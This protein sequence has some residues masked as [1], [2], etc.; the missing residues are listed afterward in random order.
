V[1]DVGCGAGWASIALARAY[2][3]ARIDGFDADAASVELAQR[4]AAREGVA[5]RVTFRVHDASD[6][7]GPAADAAGYDYDLVLAFETVHDLAR[8]V[9]AL[10]TMSRLARP[11]GTVLVAEHRVG[12]AFAAPGD[13]V[14]RL[15]Y[16][17]S[18]L[19]CLPTGMA[20]GTPERPAAGTGTVLRPAT[21]RRYAREAGFRAAEVLPIEHDLF[22]FYRLVS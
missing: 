12:E 11:G 1:A 10:T 14:E 16:G 6:P 17:I 20:G 22:R 15:S 8:P 3:R 7:A 5:D 19:F 4:N 9:E 18:L 2:P 21:L 13:P